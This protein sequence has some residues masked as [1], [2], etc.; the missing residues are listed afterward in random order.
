MAKRIVIIVDDGLADAYK[1]SC[2][3]RGLSM[4]KDLEAY[5]GEAC[6]LAVD[7]PEELGDEQDGVPGVGADDR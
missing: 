1:E 3:T 5:M 7:V 4:Q 2:R 6:H